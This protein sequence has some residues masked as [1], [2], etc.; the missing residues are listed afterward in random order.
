MCVCVCAVTVSNS[1]EPFCSWNCN[2]HSCDLFWMLVM[3][4]RFSSTHDKKKRQKKIENWEKK[5]RKKRFSKQY[6]LRT[7]FFLIF[8]FLSFQIF[9][10]YFL[11]FCKRRV[12]TFLHAV[13][14]MKTSTLL[15]IFENRFDYLQNKHKSFNFMWVNVKTG[16]GKSNKNEKL[17]SYICVKIGMKITNEQK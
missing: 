8:R 4:V 11:I 17:K 6:C 1:T 13:I 10:F 12:N 3:S 14:A 16:M 5:N 2:Q 7:H 15:L 9:F